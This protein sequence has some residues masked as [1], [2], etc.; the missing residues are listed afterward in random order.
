MSSELTGGTYTVIVKGTIQ[1]GIYSTFTFTVSGSNLVRQRLAPSFNSRI[2]R[3]LKIPVND[4]REYSLPVLMKS[5]DLVVVHSAPLPSYVSFTFP[6]YTFKPTTQTNLGVSTITGLLKNTFGSISF[7][8]QV[9]VEN[10]APS[11]KQ[12]LQD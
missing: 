6:V 7:R 10:Q 3:L 4:E 9:L 2:V 8:F 12:S 11:F 1:S 5:E